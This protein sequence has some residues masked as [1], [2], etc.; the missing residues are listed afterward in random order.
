[1][2]FALAGRLLSLGAEEPLWKAILLGVVLMT[3][4]AVGAYFGLHAV[5]QGNRR[6]WIGLGANLLLALIAVVMPIREGLTGGAT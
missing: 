5:R 4:F 1:M 3:P 6:G 2:G